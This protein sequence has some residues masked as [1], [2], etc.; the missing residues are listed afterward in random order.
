[1]T[2]ENPKQRRRPQAIFRAVPAMAREAFAAWLRDGAPHWSAAIAFY[3]IFS[4]APVLLLSTVIA[5]ALW[6]AG[7]VQR[8]VLAWFEP[9]LGER[10]AA[11]VSTLISRAL[12]SESGA[13][14]GAIGALVLLVGAT[15]VFVSLRG[16]LNAVWNVAGEAPGGVAGVLLGRLRAL[17]A[18]L[19]LAVLIAAS[20]LANA[21]AA[22]LGGRLRDWLPIPLPLVRGAEL[23]VSLVALTLFFAMLFKWLPDAVLAWKDVWIGAATTALLFVGGRIAIGAYLGTSGI[24]S[25]YG[26]AGSIV[27]I[28]LWVY[29]S[30]MIFLYG[31]ELTQV[32]ARRFG[33]RIRPAGAE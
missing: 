27:M 12:P 22:A 13:L 4:L 26:V 9:L 6:K 17:A 18:L 1:M 32:Y 19:G 2:R 21:A 11:Q 31:A 14:A 25:A 5:S 30:A 8:D 33:S 15:A 24:A 23:L 7:P 3:T 10:G 28:L 29:Y 16:A 20:V